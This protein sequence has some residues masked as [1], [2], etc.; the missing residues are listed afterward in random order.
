[1]IKKIFIWT[2]PLP[3]LIFWGVSVY[4]SKFE[5]EGQSAA[6]ILLLALVLLSLIMGVM[7]MV[8]ITRALKQRAPIVNLS[9]STLMAGSLFI[10]FIARIIAQELI[11]NFG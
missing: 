7:G 2:S 5:G 6:G 8:L 1:M 4:L 9:F 3:L 10:Y 11:K